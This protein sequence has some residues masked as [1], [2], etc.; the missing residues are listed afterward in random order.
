MAGLVYIFPM[1]SSIPNGF[2]EGLF[3]LT[4]FLV[5]ALAAYIKLGSY[6][7]EV[8]N[9]TIKVIK[10]LFGAVLFVHIS[11]L[12]AGSEA[13]RA[14][15]FTGIACHCVYA[16]QLLSFPR[17]SLSSLKSIS[18]FT[19]FVVSHLVWLYHFRFHN[20]DDMSTLVVFY[21]VMVWLVPFSLVVSMEVSEFDL[22]TI[23]SP[24]SVCIGEVSS[25]NS[26]STAV[27]VNSDTCSPRIGACNYSRP[28]RSFE[29][30]K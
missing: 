15:I 29:K 22:P 14:E 6:C 17:A 8:P 23:Y 2:V 1:S 24:K 9:N 10:A 26:F 30:F 19:A 13:P 5:L 12:S 21:V 3:T 20:G 7:E 16:V 25:N 28:S 4:V 11:L 27:V 18:C